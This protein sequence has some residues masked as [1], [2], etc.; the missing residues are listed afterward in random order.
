MYSHVSNENLDKLK[1]L[2]EKICAS[3]FEAEKKESTNTILVEEIKKTID[4]ET[5]IIDGQKTNDEKLNCYERMF[6][7]LKI[8]LGNFKIS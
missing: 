2:S 1:Q 5:A 8:I 4:L 7:H 6:Q 3:E